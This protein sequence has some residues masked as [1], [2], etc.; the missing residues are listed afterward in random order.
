MIFSIV[1][2]QLRHYTSFGF[3]NLIFHIGSWHTVSIVTMKKRIYW[4]KEENA[5]SFELE[6][7]LPQGK[8]LCLYAV[9]FRIIIT[10]SFPPPIK[11][12][13]H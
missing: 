12:K 6:L 9:R 10:S 7:Y 4:S 3:V 11:K 5:V 8:I 2:N 13:T 1:F